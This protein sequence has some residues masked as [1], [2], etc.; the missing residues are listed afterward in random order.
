MAFGAAPAA[1]QAPDST[2]RTPTSLAPVVVTSD[3]PLHVIGH[4]R[5]V[6]DG[7]IYNGKK[8]EVIT[9]DSLAANSA[10]DVE[11]QILGRIP[12]AHFS[13]TQGAGFPSNGVGFRG[14]DPTQS[15]EVNTRQ[16]GI[17]LAADVYGY[18]EAYY[19]PPTE[20]LERIEVV[21]GAGSL[22]FGPQ[23]GGSVNY[24]VRRGAISTRPRVTSQ[25][26]AGS[27]GL[28]NSFNSLGGGTGTLS[29]YGF[30]HFRTVDGWRPNSDLRQGTLY[31]S[32]S[33][34]ASERLTV[35]AEFTGHRNR[36]HMAGG[37]SD[38]QFAADPRASYRARNWL[39]SPWNIAA[40][41]ARYE[42]SPGVSVLTTLS[43]QSSDRHLVWRNEDGGPA[44][45][46]AIDPATGEFVP[47]EL[48]RETFR[49]ITLESRL[50]AAHSV[51]GREAVIATGV[52][53]LGSRLHR[54]EGA[55]GSTG[56]DFDMRIHG[57]GWER[58]I[59][60]NTRSGSL[61]AEELVHVTD[62][63]SLTPGLRLEYVRS[64]AKGYTD[65][66]S[67]FVPKSVSYPLAGIG[68]E[69]ATG[70]STVLYANVS[71]A[72]R[73]IL[74]S[75]LTPLGSV[76][77]VD[78][79]LRASRG[80]NADLGWRGNL[81]GAIKFD[82]GAFYLVSRNR[83]GVR[84]R[85]DAGGEYEESANI[86]TSRHRGAEVYLELDPFAF[87]AEPPKWGT[88]DV[89]TSFAFVD[90]R[91][92]SGEFRGNRVEQAPRVVNRIGLTYL[93]RGF[94]GTLQSSYTSLSYG[95]ANNSN[96]P[97]EDA[98][99][100][101]VPSYLIFDLSLKAPVA[102]RHSLSAGINNLFDRKYFTKRTGE[103]PGPGILPGQAR[104]FYA[105]LNVAL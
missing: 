84:T 96:V 46:D 74:Y 105:G 12:G 40:L 2:Q 48:E 65:V 6:T 71:E 27:F 31:G 83:I 14:L 53:A 78:P 81:G 21:R 8:T 42:F 94:V 99:A 93:S 11:R 77:R 82:A 23:Y 58:A 47:R 100:G 4:M 59:R 69:Y 13:E 37:L 73:P 75:A 26:T 15:V 63:W 29:Y 43:G 66:T 20:A 76:I 57:A 70:V 7:V 61:F 89:F 80:Y 102:G 49:N 22:A 24:V 92:V 32:V 36:I 52:R 9:I 18:P 98:A 64:A 17:N 101:R 54:L 85:N 28:F 33:M 60:F 41:R 16:N 51:L 56:S 62:R 68:S 72:Y 10:Q 1:G 103:Y 55:E 50:T 19:T 39:A 79:A 86:G 91:Y 3:R 25:L 90:A 5:D 87:R 45:A 97:H 67:S 35:D 88:V 38:E 30:A 95:D 104:S 34:R 44:E